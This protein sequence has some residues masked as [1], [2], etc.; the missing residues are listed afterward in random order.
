MITMTN[1]SGQARDMA[2]GLSKG[3]AFTITW[4]RGS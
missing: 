3:S 1:N 2:S 4:L